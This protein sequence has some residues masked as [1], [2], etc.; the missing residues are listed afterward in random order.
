MKYNSV[1]SY[2]STMPQEIQI[3]LNEIRMEILLAAPH[4][5]ESISYVMPAYRLGRKPLVYFAAFKNHIGF[6]A[7]PSAHK[8]FEKNFL[9][10]KQGKRLSAVSYQQSHAFITY[11]EYCNISGARKFS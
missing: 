3:L 6:Y 2:I 1:D 10:Y 11:P 5:E 7:T 8:Q 9:K 4:A